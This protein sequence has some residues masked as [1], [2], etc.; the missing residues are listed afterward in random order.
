MPAF[1]VYGAT[2]TLDKS[3]LNVIATRLEARGKHP[4]FAQMLQDYLEVMNIDTAQE[5]LDVGCGTGVAARAIAKREG[6]SGTVLGIDLSDF[7]VK[8]AS[9]Q[10]DQEDLK[11]KLTFKTGDSRSLRL[12]DS[13][14]DAVVLHTLVSHLDDPLAAHKEAARV[15]KPGGMI[16]VFDGDY[17]SL[18]FGHQDPA[19]G[20]QNDEMIISA[21]ITQPPRYAPNAAFT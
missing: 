13:S 8:V 9:T 15:L 21:V 12:T 1:D 18:T 19:Q 3:T 16:G 5:V 6:F 2:D 17:A 7:L 11:G 14:F 20:Q 10:A 4:F